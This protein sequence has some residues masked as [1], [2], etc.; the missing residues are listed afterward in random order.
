MDRKSKIFFAALAFLIAG[1]IGATFWRIIIKK[2]YV[3]ESQVDCD[4][5][6]E[7]CFVWKC[8]PESD[9]EGEKCT[10][11]PESDIWYFK[12]ARRSAANI[13]LCDPNKDETCEPF[14]CEEG[15]KD[16]SEEFCTEENMEAQY[17]SSCVDPVQ[18][19]IDN[20]IEEEEAV[21]EEGDEECLAGEEADEECAEGE[22]CAAQESE[23]AVEDGTEAGAE[24]TQEV[25]ADENSGEVVQ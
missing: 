9:V 13:P 10:G 24:E 3:I 6:A 18:F 16:C 25:P 20:P 19:S 15:E 21:C 11:D 5:Y 12:V 7:K 22:E 4:P 2:D 14:V 1:S 8:D 23:E 17:A